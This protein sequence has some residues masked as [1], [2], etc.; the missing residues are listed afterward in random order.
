LWMYLQF[1]HPRS[2]PFPVNIQRH[3]C[4]VRHVVETITISREENQRVYLNSQVLRANVAKPS[5]N[6][7]YN[8]NFYEAFSFSPACVA[9]CFIHSKKKLK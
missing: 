7:K 4:F 1:L 5:V 6:Q 2:F 3:S 8:S 9:H